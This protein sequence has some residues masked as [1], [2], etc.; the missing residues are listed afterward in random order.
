MKLEKAGASWWR[1]A[2][3]LKWVGGDWKSWSGLVEIGK[4]EVGWWRLEKLEW[5]GG[6]WKSWSGLVEIERLPD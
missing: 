1:L 5:V 2:E 3:K 4:A 6:S